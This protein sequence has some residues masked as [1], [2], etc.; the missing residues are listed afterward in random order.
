[1]ENLVL[2]TSIINTPSTPLSYGIRSVYNSEQRFE[3]TKLTIQSIKE[4]IPNSKIFIVEC[5]ELNEEQLNYFLQNSTYFLNLFNN[6]ELTAKMHSNSK[7]LC[8]GTMT[9]CA[10][11]FLLQNDIKFDSL[12]KISGRYYLSEN[13][14]YNNF[15]ND[16][17][18]IKYINN[19]INN[20]FTGLYKLPRSCTEKLKLFLQNNVNKMML[21]IGYE[22]LF[23][24][25]IKTQKINK[26]NV[27]PIGLKGYVSVSN[28]F[29]NG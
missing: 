9:F 2:I 18:V 22:V 27:S 24:E 7:S 28:E 12:I 21:Y 25:F 19:D 5:S 29:F 6:E 14:D 13:F 4:K 10:L 23:A 1:M 3:Q 8:E 16:E 20:V 26:N 17:L 11:D 15:N